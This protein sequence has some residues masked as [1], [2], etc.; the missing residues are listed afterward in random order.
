[1][2][3]EPLPRARLSTATTISLTPTTTTISCESH[4]IFWSLRGEP[5]AHI[6]TLA[7]PL[8]QFARRRLIYLVSESMSPPLSVIPEMDR[9]MLKN[10]SGHGWVVQKFGGTSVGKFPDK[11]AEDIVRY[12]RLCWLRKGRPSELTRASGTM[13]RTTGWWSCAQHGVP[14]KRR[15]EPRAGECAGPLPHAPGRPTRAWPSPDLPMPCGVTDNVRRRAGYWRCT[16][17]CAQ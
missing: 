8:W 1:M 14:A 12:E 15:Q 5:T 10:P 17:S 13:S 3:K 6:R 2:K 11:I 4:W 16:R 7:A 9:P